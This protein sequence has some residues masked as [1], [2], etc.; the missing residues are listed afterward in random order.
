[1]FTNYQLNWSEQC[2]VCVYDYSLEKISCSLCCY[3]C[4]CFTWCHLMLL[5]TNIWYAIAGSYDIALMLHEAW[6]WTSVHGKQ[7]IWCYVWDSCESFINNIY[8]PYAF[9]FI[10]D[11]KDEHGYINFRSAFGSDIRNTWPLQLRLRIIRQG[12]DSI[13]PLGSS[14]ISTF[15]I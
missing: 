9:H 1:L 7:K 3:P 11:T 14:G 12:M 15:L 8:Q 13:W 5:P 6:L 2:V 4:F 10:W